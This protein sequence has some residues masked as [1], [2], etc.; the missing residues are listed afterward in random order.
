MGESVHILEVANTDG[1]EPF[2]L[3][4]HMWDLG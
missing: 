4:C 3:F 2:S 1:D